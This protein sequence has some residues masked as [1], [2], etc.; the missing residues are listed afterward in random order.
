MLLKQ[1]NFLDED[2][3]FDESEE[4]DES[5]LAK[6][7]KITQP[8]NIEQEIKELNQE[9]DLDLDTFIATVFFSNLI[10]N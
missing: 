5:S 4:D 3:T 10:F 2:A 7:E 1:F 8:A 6:E 9:A